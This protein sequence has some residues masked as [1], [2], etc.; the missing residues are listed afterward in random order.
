MPSKQSAILTLCA[1]MNN[2]IDTILDAASKGECK[3]PP[4]VEPFCKA[5]AA[6][7]SPSMPQA[8][9]VGIK[10]NLMDNVEAE[11]ATLKSSQQPLDELTI[12]RLLSL[13]TNSRDQ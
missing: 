8:E 1:D 4:L 2:D 6:K 10:V 3:R 9:K 7:S 12:V 5:A 11:A 13:E